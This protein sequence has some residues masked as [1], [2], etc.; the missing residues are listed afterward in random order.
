MYAWTYQQARTRSQR[1]D[2]AWNYV[3]HRVAQHNCRVPT[4]VFFLPLYAAV[5]AYIHQRTLGEPN[6]LRPPT[7][8]EFRSVNPIDPET[9]GTRATLW[10]YTRVQLDRYGCP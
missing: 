3:H 1:L 4:R 7:E 8:L 6:T 2:A 9:V 10:R 5:S